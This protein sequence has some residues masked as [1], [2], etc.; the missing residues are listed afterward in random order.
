MSTDVL[1]TDCEQKILYFKEDIVDGR[2][3]MSTDVSVC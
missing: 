1:V 2:Y 3:C